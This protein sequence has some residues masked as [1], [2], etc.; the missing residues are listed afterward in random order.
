MTAPTIDR[1]ALVRECRD[2]ERRCIRLGIK[3][4]EQWA[5]EWASAILDSRVG[6]AEV[7]GWIDQLH[8]WVERREKQ[9]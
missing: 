8:M 4:G 2:L 9:G 5:R 6:A 3:T 1:G 7:A